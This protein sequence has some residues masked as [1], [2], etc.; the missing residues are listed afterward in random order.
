MGVVFWKN[1]ESEMG[2]E[3]A[4]MLYLECQG[5]KG[6]TTNARTYALGLIE[7]YKILLKEYE[8]RENMG[9]NG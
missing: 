9:K 4:D 8:T 2:K 5:S 1:L 6:K 3:A 7:K